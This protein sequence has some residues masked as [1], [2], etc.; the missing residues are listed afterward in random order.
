M[1]HLVI[2]DEIENGNSAYVK[3]NCYLSVFITGHSCT[4]PDRVSLSKSRERTVTC[5]FS[6]SSIATVLHK[7]TGHFCTDPD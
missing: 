4:D 7:I 1:Q 6:S 5:Q 3:K 2:L